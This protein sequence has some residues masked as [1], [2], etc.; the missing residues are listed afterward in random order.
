MKNKL[1]IILLAFC[2]VTSCQNV[3]DVAPSGRMSLDEVFADDA[4]TSAYLNSCYLNFP[5]WANFNSTSTNMR[6]A[7]TDDAWDWYGNP[8][9]PSNK[10]YIGSATSTNPILENEDNRNDNTDDVMGFWNK[11]WQNIR[12]CNVF[13]SRIATAKVTLESDRNRWT[14]EAKALRAFYN[15][16]LIIRYGGMPIVT[17]PLGLDYD[18]KQLKREPFKACVDNIIKDCNEALATP[19]FPWR[20][21]AGNE[22]YRFTK[23]IAAAVKS[24]AILFA[25]SDLWNGGQ[26]HWAEAEAITK[27]SLDDCLANGYELYTKVNNP[28]IFQSAYQEYFCSVTDWSSTPVDKETILASS[29]INNDWI[30]FHGLPIQVAYKSGLCPSQ[31]LVDA[32]GMQVSGQPILKLDKPYLDEAHLQP[33]YNPG[34]GYNPVNPYIG[35]DPR[36]Y[37]TIYYNGAKRKN[38]A[39]VLTDIQTYYGGNCGINV[40]VR[41]RTITGYYSKKYDHPSATISAR[42]SATYRIM[43]LAELYLNY[44]EAA[45]EN[46]NLPGAVGAVNVIRARA[47]MP[48]INPASK[49]EARLLIR[50]ERRVELAYEENRYFDLRRWTKPDADLTATDRYL[51]GMWIIKTG[52]A[53]D[54][55]RFSIGDSWDT[56]T[57]SWSNTATPRACYTNKYLIWPIQ[58]V[59]SRRLE[60]ASGKKWQNPGW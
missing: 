39:G 42:I 35:R 13:L 16:E 56:S 46:G 15:F 48:N 34:S 59:E 22:A 5:K 14:A 41:A 51:T 47:G 1:L 50:N 19:E 26:T 29:Y 7:L 37:A 11:C 4:T 60:A 38:S 23:A 54:Y 27:K 10:M 36:F 43:R 6:I 25:A 53:L 8:A 49:D 32:Y 9:V 28:S 44:A 18:Y 40:N 57:G 2:G 17:S 45:N 52:T 24:S 20:I 3:L 58:L 33:N 21:S 31:E 12:R 55:K 30:Q